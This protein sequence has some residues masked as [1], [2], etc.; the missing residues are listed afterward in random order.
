MNHKI[1]DPE[2]IESVD[3]ND[4]WKAHS[5]GIELTEYPVTITY[6]NVSKPQADKNW[7]SPAAVLFTSDDSLVWPGAIENSPNHYREYSIIRS[8]AYGWKTDAKSFQYESQY[9]SKWTNWENW[10]EQNRQGS[11]CTVTAVRY[12]KYA[13]IRMENAGLIVHATTTLPDN[14]GEKLYFAMTGEQCSLTD[15]LLIRES[16]AIGPGTIDPATDKT[17]FLASARGDI[18]NVDCSGWWTAH[19]DGIVVDETPVHITY[20][21]V[22]YP[23]AKETWHA[24]LVVLYSSLDGLVNGVAYTEFSVTR[25]DSYG[26]ISDGSGYAAKDDHTDAFT[27]WESWLDKNKAG[28]TCTLTAYRK[29]DKI[30]IEHENSGLMVTSNTL[31]PFGTVLPIYVALSGELCSISD[32]HV[33][34]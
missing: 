24:P 31:I 4:W 14:A 29:G 33:R 32:I 17:S 25:S 11:I 18:P 7:H 2:L 3:C 9:S 28:V 26:W 5:C 20:H 27:D 10:L 13:L 6:R 30:V 1:E 21:S 15:F 16:E 23:H 34:H 8:D 22:S 19:S 12:G